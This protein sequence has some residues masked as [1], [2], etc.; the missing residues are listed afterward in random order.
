[1]PINKIESRLLFYFELDIFPPEDYRLRQLMT[2]TT[3]VTD[4]LSP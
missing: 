4:P 2:H 3:F 1:M